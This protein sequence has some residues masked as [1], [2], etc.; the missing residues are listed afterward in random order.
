VIAL[1]PMPTV[2]VAG[3]A[4]L[5]GAILVKM[6]EKAALRV[7]GLVAGVA[8][9]QVGAPL[10]GAHPAWWGWLVA[11]GVGAL[12]MPLL[13]RVALAPITAAIGA[14]V[15]ADASGHAGNPWIIGGIAVVGTLVQWGLFRGRKKDEEE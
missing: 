1:A 12:L 13:W 2:I 14:T 5:A 10:L 11:A 4:G 3:V 6:I 9:L 15:V 8:A 7:V